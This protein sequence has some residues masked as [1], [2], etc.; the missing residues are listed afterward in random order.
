MTDSPERCAC[1]HDVDDSHDPRAMDDSCTGCP[2]GRC[3]V[4]PSYT[5]DPC[6]PEPPSLT[7]LRAA[8]LAASPDH[9]PAVIAET[10]RKYG[11]PAPVLSPFVRRAMARELPAKVLR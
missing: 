9:A 1:G 7:R 10:E 11:N 2:G 8:Y 6:D 4:A 3:A 5:P